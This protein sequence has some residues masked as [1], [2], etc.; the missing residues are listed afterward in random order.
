MKCGSL[1]Q[2]CFLK[3]HLIFKSM[4]HHLCYIHISVGKNWIKMHEVAGYDTTFDPA[5]YLGLGL[6]DEIPFPAGQFVSSGRTHIL[7]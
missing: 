5:S 4:R 6:A 1:L 7:Q 3:C 2:K